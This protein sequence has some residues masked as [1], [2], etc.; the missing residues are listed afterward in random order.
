VCWT[1]SLGMQHEISFIS[2]DIAS[3]LTANKALTS[4]SATCCLLLFGCSRGKTTRHQH[5]T[6]D[7]HTNREKRR[8]IIHRRERAERDSDK[9]QKVAHFPQREARVCNC[10]PLPAARGGY[11][12]MSFVVREPSAIYLSVLACSIPAPIVLTLIGF[13]PLAAQQT[14]PVV[15]EVV[16][17]AQAEVLC[18]WSGE[19]SQGM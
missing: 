17:S 3:S 16:L 13:A 8:K 5:R 1:N 6:T 10:C 12:F 14:V 2:S 9:R 15:L 4:L 11:V 19:V 18:W 7:L